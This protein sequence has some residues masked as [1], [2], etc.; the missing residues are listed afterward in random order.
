MKFVEVFFLGERRRKRGEGIT[1]DK[2]VV[3]YSVFICIVSV[4]LVGISI[5]TR[6]RTIKLLII[7]K[8]IFRRLS[9]KVTIL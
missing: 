3:G 6:T 5:S 9:L 4:L 1:V 8:I 2:M 7:P